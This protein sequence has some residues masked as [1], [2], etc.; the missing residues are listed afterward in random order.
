MDAY[1]DTAQNR[2]RLNIKK[3]KPTTVKIIKPS[4]GFNAVQTELGY[5]QDQNRRR[6]LFYR[7]GYVENEHGFVITPNRGQITVT[8]Y[9]L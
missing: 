3:T 8:L 2:A 9:G 7:G 4:L 1:R 5:I 6:F